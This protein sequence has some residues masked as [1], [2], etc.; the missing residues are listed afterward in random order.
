MMARVWIALGSV[1]AGL[2]LFV[3]ANF[4]HAADG[5]IAFAARE[6]FHVANDIHLIHS[7]ALVVVGLLCSVYGPKIL[8]QVA[9]AAFAIYAALGQPGERPYI[10][11]GG[12]SLTLGWVALTVSVFTFGKTRI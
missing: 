10:P 8:F 11:V 6:T 4:L 1:S 7:L 2:A 3:A 5:K 12:L 9:G